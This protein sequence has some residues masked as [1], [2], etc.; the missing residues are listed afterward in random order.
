MLGDFWT[1][2]IIQA[3]NPEGKRFA[4]LQ[5]EL[6][7][8]NPTTLT[9]RLKKLENQKMIKREEE[10]LDGLSVVYSLT[11]KGRGI[12]PILNQIRLFADKFL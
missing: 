8:V 4:Q 3:L 6:S 10:T 11:N 9:S 1:L 12:L 7:G 2:A 5:R